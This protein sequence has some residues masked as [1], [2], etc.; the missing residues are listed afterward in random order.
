[1]PGTAS[2]PHPLLPLNFR[3]LGG[4]LTASSR[5]ARG[6]LFRTAQLS[7]LSEA[8]AEHLHQEYGVSVYLDFRAELEILRDGTPKA[9]LARHVSWQRHP[10]D[11][12]DATFKA[13]ATPGPTDW[14]ALYTRAFR[15]LRPELLGAVQL[16]AA[17]ETPVAFGCWAGKDRTGMVAALVLSLLGVEDDWIADDF[18]KTGAHLLAA[19]HRFSSIWR[20]R[21]DA[22]AELVQ[23]HLRTAPES[24]SGFLREVRQQFGSV[25]SALG[26]AEATL[27]A[28][29]V[30][31]LEPTSTAPV[32]SH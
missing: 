14:Q 31:Y 20:D 7:E 18:A 11:I 32:H 17:A 1:M 30:R 9:L 25:Q 24:I 10:F 3:D 5:V 13:I 23:A 29:S 15:R 4:A 27:D 6:R 8:E 16:I 21:P 19:R 12:S 28:L 2:E 26:L 22:E